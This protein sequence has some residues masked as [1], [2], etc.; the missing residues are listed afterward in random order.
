MYAEVGPRQR[1]RITPQHGLSFLAVNLN[2]GI[3]MKNFD[4][5]KTGNENFPQISD[6]VRQQQNKRDFAAGDRNAKEQH[7]R[8]KKMSYT[9]WAAADQALEDHERLADARTHY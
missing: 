5:T 1:E 2:K 6:T 3:Q 9:G 4:P 8:L 7:E